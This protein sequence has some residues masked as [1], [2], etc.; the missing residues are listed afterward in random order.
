V[1]VGVEQQ[2][3]GGGGGGGAGGR[4]PHGCVPKCTEQIAVHADKNET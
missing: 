1:R 2:S 3:M 4:M